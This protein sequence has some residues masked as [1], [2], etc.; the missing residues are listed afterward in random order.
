MTN[1]VTNY[2][3]TL[4]TGEEGL[5]V[6]TQYASIIE[7]ELYFREI[8]KIVPNKTVNFGTYKLRASSMTELLDKLKDIMQQNDKSDYKIEPKN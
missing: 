2:R 7:G 1:T 8:I 5:F 4:S 6:A 3:I